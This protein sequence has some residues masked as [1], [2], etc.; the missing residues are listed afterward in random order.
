MGSTYGAGPDGFSNG[1]SSDRTPGF[2]QEKPPA[3]G[4]TS[5]S[6]ATEPVE[7]GNGAVNGSHA[8]ESVPGSPQET[9]MSEIG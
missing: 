7:I 5:E 4:I 8:A 2:D 1:R 3:D 6:F 9:E